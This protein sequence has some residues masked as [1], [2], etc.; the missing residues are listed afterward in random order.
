[1]MLADMMGLGKVC[2]L[3]L[4][5]YYNSLN[6]A[7]S[8]NPGPRQPPPISTCCLTISFLENRHHIEQ[9]PEMH[10]RQSSSDYVQPQDALCPSHSK[11]PIAYYYQEH[12]VTRRMRLEPLPGA[13]LVLVPAS[14][15]GNW[16]SE[17]KELKVS[18]TTSVRLRIQHH[19]FEDLMLTEEEMSSLLVPA[20]ENLDHPERSRPIP[21]TISAEA[22]IVVT[23]VQS[24]KTRLQIWYDRQSKTGKSYSGDPHWGRIL[25][26]ESHVTP[27]YAAQFYQ[28]VK[29]HMSGRREPPSVVI[30]TATPALRN[31]VC[32][33]LGSVKTINLV[34]PEISR[35]PECR[36]FADPTLFDSLGERYRQIRESEKQSGAYLD[37]DKEEVIGTVRALWA[38]YCLR[39]RV[40]TRQNGKLLTDIPP[41][42][43]YDV[44]CPTRR[45]SASH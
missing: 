6:M 22:L 14:L 43:C 36:H 24:Y 34:S 15:L 16:H 2:L 19:D 30:I 33:M 37:E 7:S 12:S 18:T 26:D 25:R 9:H 38:A 1:M 42:E 4:F 23:S 8:A 40:E 45:V 3:G 31:G 44:Q 11:W 29:S 27:N 35:H 39:R 21:S 20:Q 32:D 10:C 28:I 13:S 17:W 41:L 5:P